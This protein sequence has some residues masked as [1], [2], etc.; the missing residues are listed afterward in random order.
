M[1]QCGGRRVGFQRLMFTMAMQRH[2]L[3]GAHTSP[4][5]SSSHKR[6]VSPTDPLLHLSSC[7]HQ[8]SPIQVPEVPKSPVVPE[9]LVPPPKNDA[10]ELVPPPVLYAYEL[11][12]PPNGEVVR[13]GEPELFGGGFIELSILPLYPYHN[14]GHI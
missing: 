4:S 6:H 9:A 8:V 12:P 5:S 7:R 1:H 13:D 3:L 2:L 10:S 14:V 11:V